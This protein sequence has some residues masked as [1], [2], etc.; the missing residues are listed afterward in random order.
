MTTMMSSGTTALSQASA[1]V[2]GS[3]PAVGMAMR[4]GVTVEDLN[5]GHWSTCKGLNVKI[6]SKHIES[7]GQYIDRMVV[8]ERVTFDPITLER[9][10]SA[11][12]SAKLQQWLAQ[13]VKSTHYYSDPDQ[14]R[15]RTATITLYDAQ[16]RAVMTWTLQ[17]VVPVS[18]QGPSLNATSNQVA[19]EVLVVEHE[20]FLGE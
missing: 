7:G 13:Y 12:D 10:V 18:W 5:L 6:A 16:T 2:L 19:T 20:G 14:L 11:A 4:F 1:G 3:Y 15:A 9:A 17:H 8:P